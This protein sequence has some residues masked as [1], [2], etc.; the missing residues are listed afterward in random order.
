MEE[1]KIVEAAAKKA[2]SL[3]KGPMNGH[4]NGHTNGHGHTNGRTNGITAPRVEVDA[5]I[6]S[7]KM[8]GRKKEQKVVA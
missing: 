8:D 1:E 4:T 6:A 3:N 7:M 5:E 2:G